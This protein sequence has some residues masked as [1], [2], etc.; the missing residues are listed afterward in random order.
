MTNGPASNRLHAAAFGRAGRILAEIPEYGRLAWEA[1]GF[2]AYERQN[3][4]DYT[5]TIVGG[6]GPQ[7][8]YAL[9]GVGGA[10]L[11]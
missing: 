8:A 4:P 3:G 11:R 7:L 2:R 10:R 5:L 6:G 9:V 1:N